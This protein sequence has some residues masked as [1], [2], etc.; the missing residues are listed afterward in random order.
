MSAAPDL[1]ARRAELSPG[2]VA[3]DDRGT[4]RRWTFAQVDAEAA[5]LAGA[6]R[7]RGLGR[8][9]RVAI[10]SLNRAEVFIALFAALKSGLVLVPLNWRQPAPELRAA[11]DS[12]GC[13][14]LIHDET[15]A[16]TA[17]AL[18]LPCLPMLADGGFAPAEP[19]PADLPDESAPWYLLFTSGTTGLPKAVIQTPRM[20]LATAMNLAQAT[21]LTADSRGLCFLPL[22]HTAGINLYALPIFLWGGCTTILPRFDPADLLDTLTAARITHVFGVPTIYQALLA[23]PGLDR[24]DLASVRHWACGGA[25]L[26]GP[27]LTALAARG[28]RVAEGFGMTETGPTGFLMPP[29][30]A[31]LR[32]GSIGKPQLLTEARLD[33]VPDGQPGT[34]E[35]QMRGATITPGYFANPAATAAAFTADGWLRTGDIACRDAEGFYA[36]VDRIKDMFISGGE[37]VYP[38]EVERALHAHPGVAEVAVIGVP[39]PRWGEVGAAF[40]ILRAG[41]DPAALDGWLRGRIAAYKVP[42][43]WRFVA[44]LPRTPSGKV[45]KPRLR[46]GFE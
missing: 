17:A 11:L 40:V 13:A 43:H 8:G 19:L 12:I 22:F 44:D 28:L 33:G 6:L 29:D 31:G 46:E 21:G 10:L 24:A 25:A 27:V 45:V 2:A 37:N 26:P 14:L 9:D 15:H 38:A 5:S 18:G 3:F 36:I 42:K 16:Q 20:A 39:D 41:A 30:Q 34:G 1:S 32:P 35:L 4:G 23:H 7:A